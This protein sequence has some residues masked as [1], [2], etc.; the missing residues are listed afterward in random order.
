MAREATDHNDRTSKHSRSHHRRRHRHSACH[1]SDGDESSISDAKDRISDEISQDPVPRVFTWSEPVLDAHSSGRFQYQARLTPEGYQWT[2]SGSDSGTNPQYLSLTTPNMPHPLNTA[3][4]TYPASPYV[5][6]QPIQSEL[7]YYGP[8]NVVISPAVALNNEGSRD[9]ASREYYEEEKPRDDRS[10]PRRNKSSS[11]GYR[12]E[13]KGEQGHRRSHSH[14]RDHSS[15]RRRHH[16]SKS[17]EGS[18]HQRHT[19]RG[20]GHANPHEKVSDWLHNYEY[21]N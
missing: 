14:H 1:H 17:H 15:H 3:V 10:V 20:H 21:A 13:R 12:N 4:T 11:N 8:S 2:I 18:S 7:Q 19:N 6:H 16:R 5:V 9:Y